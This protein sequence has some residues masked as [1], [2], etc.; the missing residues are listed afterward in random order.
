ML[1]KLLF[2]YFLICIS[3]SSAVAQ[4]T[5]GQLM[6]ERLQKEII[7]RAAEFDSLVLINFA[8]YWSDKYEAKGFAYEQGKLYRVIISFNEDSAYYLSV[9]RVIKR[10]VRDERKIDSLRHLNYQQ[11]F[12]FSDDSLHIHCRQIQGDYECSDV[13]DA[14]Y[15]TL[16]SVKPSINQ[17]YIREVYALAFYQYTIEQ[18]V[19]KRIIDEIYLLYGNE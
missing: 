7:K 5:Q 2:I 16:I 15:Y 18:R 11:I 3:A 6:T 9:N 19:M 17:Y 4:I 1:R 13:S 14:T 12:S 10:R 8:G